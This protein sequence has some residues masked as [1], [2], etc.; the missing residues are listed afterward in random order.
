M[1][2]YLTQ[3][4]TLSVPTWQKI[5]VIKIQYKYN[6]IIFQIQICKRKTR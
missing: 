3:V 5:L 4:A 2:V 1:L 6:L